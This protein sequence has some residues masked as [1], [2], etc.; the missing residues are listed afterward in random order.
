MPPADRPAVGKGV[1]W[2]PQKPA[3]HAG[4]PPVGGAGMPPADRPAVGKGVHWRPQKPA[5]HAGA[6]P[7]GGAGMPPA[8]R[9]AVGKGVHW[10]PL[11]HPVGDAATP[12][13]PSCR[14]RRRITLT[15]CTPARCTRMPE[16]P[17]QRRQSAPPA[18]GWQSGN[19]AVLKTARCD[20]LGGSNPLP[21]ARRS[22]Y[23]HWTA[24][25]SRIQSPVSQAGS[26]P[27]SPGGRC[28]RTPGG[29]SA[30]ARRAPPEKGITDRPCRSRPA[31]AGRHERE[32]QRPRKA[33]I[34]PC[35]THPRF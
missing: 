3:P 31:F 7:V 12:A 21:G 14:R 1:H 27:T 9:P 10:R 30:A 33:P 26:L 20:N 18:P 8:D 24:P 19:A 28:R 34:G 16:R 5:P 2:R 22:P 23:K 15:R 25:P 32:P 11:R 13:P 35:Y 6:P 17:V 29:E 4:A